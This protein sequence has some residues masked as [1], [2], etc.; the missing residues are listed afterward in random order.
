MTQAHNCPHT[1]HTSNNG[2]KSNKTLYVE[3]NA[4]RTQALFS[5]KNPIQWNKRHQWAGDTERKTKRAAPM[6]NQNRDKQQGEN[7]NKKYKIKIK[8]QKRASEKKTNQSR[9]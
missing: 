1:R 7:D 8:R 9:R 2:Q 4:M 5:F 3:T 6:E